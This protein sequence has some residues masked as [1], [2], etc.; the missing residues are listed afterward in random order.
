RSADVSRCGSGPWRPSHCH[1][2]DNGYTFHCRGELREVV[3]SRTKLPTGCRFWF[4]NAGTYD[5]FTHRSRRV[6]DR[7]SSGRCRYD[8]NTRTLNVC[9]FAGRTKHPARIPI[10]WYFFTDSEQMKMIC[11]LWVITLTTDTRSLACRHQKNCPNIL[12]GIAGS[13]YRLSWTPT[14][15]MLKKQ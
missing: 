8:N 1:C 5:R 14:L 2:K 10:C 4:S 13:Q 12:E 15:M 6:P 11:F 9:I 7:S 3:F